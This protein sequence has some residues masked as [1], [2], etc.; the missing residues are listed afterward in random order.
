MSSFLASIFGSSTASAPAAS[1]SL[2]VQTGNSYLAA[3][4]SKNVQAITDLF[5]EKAHIEN[6]CDD[7]TILPDE[8]FQGGKA[9]A[10]TTSKF[11]VTNTMVGSGKDASEACVAMIMSD[12]SDATK[13]VWSMHILKV[14]QIDSMPKIVSMRVVEAAGF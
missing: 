12:P 1:L 9:W 8:C 10:E 6:T 7:S 4:Q 2:A 5:A 14:E 3:M 11:T 13:T